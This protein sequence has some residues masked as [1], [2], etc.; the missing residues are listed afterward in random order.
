MLQFWFC[1]FS[2]QPQKGEKQVEAPNVDVDINSL[3]SLDGLGIDVSFL[4]DI[5]NFASNRLFKGNNKIVG[6]QFV[7]ALFKVNESDRSILYS[8]FYLS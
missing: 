8:T 1:T 5:G 3:M 4:K 6:E 7:Q 2:G